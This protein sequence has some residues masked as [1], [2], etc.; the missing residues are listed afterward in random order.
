MLPTRE[1]VLVVV[2]LLV[3]IVALQL[4]RVPNALLGRLLPKWDFLLV[5]N[6]SPLLTGLA[7]NPTWVLLY[8]VPVLLEN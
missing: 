4:H 5:R 2:A 8:A 1:V 7:T 6:V 3:I